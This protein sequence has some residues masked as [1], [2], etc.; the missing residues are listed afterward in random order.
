MAMPASGKVKWFNSQKGFG[1]IAKDDGSGDVFVH[2]SAIQGEGQYKS[3]NENDQ[4]E[5]DVVTGDRGPK[6]TNVRKI[7]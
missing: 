6:A 4:V 7:I 5:F 3:L 2:Y 1:F